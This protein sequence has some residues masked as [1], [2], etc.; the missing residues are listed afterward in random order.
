MLRHNHTP[1]CL[2]SQHGTA[3]N[4]QTHWRRKGTGAPLPNQRRQQTP[5]PTPELP[6]EPTP[7]L[8]GTSPASTDNTS[9][10]QCLEFINMPAGYAYS[11]TS[12]PCAQS[13]TLVTCAQDSEHHP[14]F[15]P[16]MLP[17]EG[18]STGSYTI[19]F[20]VMQLTFILMTRAAY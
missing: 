20:V 7:P 3:E 12:V 1:R 13:V 9:G 15:D 5:E 10:A 17:A 18:T 16:D 19:C 6:P 11:H 14:D 8:P 4:L 2:P